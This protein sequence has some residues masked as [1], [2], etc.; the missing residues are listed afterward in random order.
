M[1]YFDDLNPYLVRQENQPEPELPP[2]NPGAIGQ[3]YLGNILKLNI[4]KLGKFYFTY[5]DSEKWRDKNY[6]GIVEDVGRDYILIKD[7]SSEK[8]FLLSFIYLLWIEFDEEL[9]FQF[10]YR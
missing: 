6:V 10:S 5:S 8:R 2:V 7:P 9:D 4:G 1:N 3:T